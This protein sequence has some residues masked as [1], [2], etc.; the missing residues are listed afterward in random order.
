MEPEPRDSE[1]GAG[2]SSSDGLPRAAVAKLVKER[3]PPHLRTKPDARTA[4]PAGEFLQMLTSE[5]NEAASAEKK[6]TLSEAHLLGALRKLG[7]PQLAAECE[8]VGEAEHGAQ[9]ARVRA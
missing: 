9:A 3:L 2:A 7:Y 5:A 8:A 6:K 4:S 1:S